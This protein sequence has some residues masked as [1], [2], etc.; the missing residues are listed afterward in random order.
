[1]ILFVTQKKRPHGMLGSR[2]V[3]TDRI[4]TACHGK[5]LLESVRCCKAAG[6]PASEGTQ[7]LLAIYISLLTLSH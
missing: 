4:H 3:S 2:R 5:I 7:D 6:R 1:M